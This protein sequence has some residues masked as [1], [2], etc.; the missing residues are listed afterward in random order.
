MTFQERQ[1]SY[2]SRHVRIPLALYDKN[3][4]Q[5]DQHPVH[6]DFPF[7]V[8][9]YRVVGITSYSRIPYPYLVKRRKLKKMRKR[10]IKLFMQRNWFTLDPDKKVIQVFLVAAL[11]VCSEWITT[12]E[13][14]RGL[15]F[16]GT[17][18]PPAV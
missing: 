8:E 1:G 6:Y 9:L 7:R 18:P 14:Q 12:A 13:I 4:T 5:I 2:T 15:G 16:T 11:R 17:N 10:S 3:Y